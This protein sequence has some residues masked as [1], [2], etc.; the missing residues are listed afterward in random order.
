MATR[1]RQIDFDRQPQ[2]VIGEP[3]YSPDGQHV[4]SSQRTMVEP[5]ELGVDGM[6]ELDSQPAGAG[7]EVTCAILQSLD[8]EDARRAVRRSQLASGWCRNLRVRPCRRT[9]P[10]DAPNI[11]P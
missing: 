2:P 10:S 6:G 1:W 4:V 9:A 8:R 11:Q 5:P 3:E 7:D